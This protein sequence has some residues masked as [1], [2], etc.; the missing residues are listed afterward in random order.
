MLE[1]KFFFYKLYNS[2]YQFFYIFNI[3]LKTKYDIKKK[4]DL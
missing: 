1:R 4:D 3:F 2:K